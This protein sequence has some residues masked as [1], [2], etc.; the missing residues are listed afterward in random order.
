MVTVGLTMSE[1]TAGQMDKK[2]Y[3]QTNKQTNAGEK[4]SRRA[5]I[6]NIQT[7]QRRQSPYSRRETIT[8]EPFSKGDSRTGLTAFNI[9]PSL[10]TH[11]SLNHF[12]LQTSE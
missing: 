12:I 9:Q 6:I 2:T 8:R 5:T 7:N 10:A 1:K 3:K 4:T 11:A